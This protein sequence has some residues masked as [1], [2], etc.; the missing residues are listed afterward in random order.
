MIEKSSTS[1]VCV[2]D[3]LTL[4]SGRAR[5]FIMMKLRGRG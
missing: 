1:N 2:T 3:P 5:W 4:R